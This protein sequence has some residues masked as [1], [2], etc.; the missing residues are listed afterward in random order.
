MRNDADLDQ[1]G[2]VQRHFVNLSLVILFDVLQ[3]A[4]VASGHEV[5]GRTLTTE[6][7]RTTDSVRN[8]NA[9]KMISKTA[10]HANII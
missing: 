5:D 9:N 1:I 4:L 10:T 6:T 3:I 7:T 8:E 2:H